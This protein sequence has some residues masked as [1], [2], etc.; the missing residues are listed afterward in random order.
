MKITENGSFDTNADLQIKNFSIAASGKA[1][2][3]LSKNIYT[4]AVKAIVRELCC[5]AID[6]HQMNGCKD[7][8]RV[9]LP[10][11][12][13]PHFIVSDNG[14]GMSDEFVNKMYSSYFASDKTSSNEVI[15]GLGLGSKTP[16][17]YTN[18]FIVS[19]AKDGTRNEYIA[20]KDENNI[21][22][23][24]RVKSE[25][26][27]YTGTT[28]DVL[29]D[30]KN[31]DEFII[32]ARKVFLVFDQMPEIVS[33]AEIF[34]NETNQEEYNS[35]R[36]I[37]KAP[38]VTNLGLNNQQ[39]VI[40]SRLL[41]TSNSPF[42]VI[43]GNVLYAVKCGNENQEKWFYPAPWNK[44]N[45]LGFKIIRA[46]IG[47]ITD[48]QPSREE[49]NYTDRVVKYLSTNFNK[50]YDEDSNKVKEM[51]VDEFARWSLETDRA[52]N[53]LSID[54]EK[55]D[56][57]RN[58]KDFFTGIKGH[59]FTVDVKRKSAF[60]TERVEM[61]TDQNITETQR[62]FHASAFFA[63]TFIDHNN[64]TAIIF[65]DK[66]LDKLLAQYEKNKNGTTAK[67][68]ATI[69]KTLENKNL[70]TGNEL[71]MDATAYKWFKQKVNL[72]LVYYSTLEKPKRTTTERERNKTPEFVDSN[73]REMCLDDIKDLVKAGYIV[74]WNIGSANN[75][76]TVK[77]NEIR[78]NPKAKSAEVVTYGMDMTNRIK[79]IKDRA[80]FLHGFN[81]IGKYKNVYCSF[82]TAKKYG[83]W[84]ESSA[85]KDS[86][87]MMMVM[88][89]K[90]RK[91]ILDA[92]NSLSFDF[93][94]KYSAETLDYIIER[95]KETYHGFENIQFYRQNNKNT[96]SK[97]VVT[98]RIEEFFKVCL[99]MCDVESNDS[100]KPYAEKLEELEAECIKIVND[101]PSTDYQNL[102]ESQFP[103]MRHIS[104]YLD[105]SMMD[106]VVDY[107]AL[108]CGLRRK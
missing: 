32:A 29:V 79:N 23:I 9:S 91:N 103:M 1:F 21:P 73:N 102:F 88:L 37:L 8:I 16:F 43:M 41:D 52:R 26:A 58:R 62:S 33:G 61:I 78:K 27:D 34:Y 53:L 5:N 54:Q 71:W 28:I 17:A 56:C 72:P 89:L 92:V 100:L 86:G 96:M 39:Q 69:V 11:L 95:G 59:V 15:G 68:S 22:S 30:P 90:N 10:T 63:R 31:I 42:G 51:S 14:V 19:S 25:P 36:E 83:L 108:S 3:I 99:A 55:Y 64:L 77:T 106:D 20:F 76:R 107:L 105:D 57:Y 93:P 4:D 70:T 45:Y 85:L 24:T 101:K 13:N 7:P 97:E 80:S 84:N 87:T 46:A 65:E 75:S 66:D 47:D 98:K 74:G 82:L 18:Q 81:L 12:E 50:S 48:I 60:I 94:L 67:A 2:S 38:E 35:L 40:L 44:Y 104:S 49:F 6:A